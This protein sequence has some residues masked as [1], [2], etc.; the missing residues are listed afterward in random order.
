MDPEIIIEFLNKLDG[1]DIYQEDGENNFSFEKEDIFHFFDPR[2]MELKFKISGT[3]YNEELNLELGDSYFVINGSPYCCYISQIDHKGKS[4]LNDGAIII[5]KINT[6]YLKTNGS[7][8]LSL[9]QE[10]KGEVFNP[11]RPIESRW[12]ILDL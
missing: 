7:N 11:N 4:R 9:F 12:E 5:I 10:Y 6:M 1:I 3:L 8:F 2:S